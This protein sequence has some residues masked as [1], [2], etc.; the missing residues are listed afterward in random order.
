MGAGLDAVAA[1][2]GC[3]KGPKERPR[4]EQIAH[5]PSSRRTRFWGRSVYW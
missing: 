4:A 2:W 3:R 5:P 1:W